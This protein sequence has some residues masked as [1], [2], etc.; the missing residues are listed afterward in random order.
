[1]KIP[2]KITVCYRTQHGSSIYKGRLIDEVF[3]LNV[4]IDTLD[5]II[6]MFSNHDPCNFHVTLYKAVPANCHEFYEY[7]TQKGISVRLEHRELQKYI[8]S[9]NTLLKY[10]ALML[11]ED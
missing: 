10:K 7:I 11:I 2:P 1:M 9:V 3:D 4:F 8:M 5:S 6:H